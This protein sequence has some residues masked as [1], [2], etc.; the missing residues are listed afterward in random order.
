MR[1]IHSLWLCALIASAVAC[2]AQVSA[3]EIAQSD[4]LARGISSYNRKDYAGAQQ[5]LLKAVNGEFKNVAVAHYYLANSLM[6]ASKTNAALDE[7]ERCYNLAPFSSFSGYCRMMLIRHGKNP[8]AVNKTALEKQPREQPKEQ[9]KEKQTAV[10]SKPATDPELA[11]L[12]SRLPRPVVITK[13]SPPASDILAGNI[14]YRSGFLGEAEIRKNRA[15]EK[16]EQ[17][18]QNLTRAESLT[19]SFVP[20]AKSFGESD[21]EFRNRRADAEKSVTSLLDPFKENVKEAETAFQN[22]SALFESCLN[23]SRGFQY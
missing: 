14:N 19:H 10:E 8:D 5:Y 17:A 21:E 2:V 12:S 15:F 6:Q 18:R 22:E 4:L 1:S 20:S 13:E 9:L 7:Y 23:A 3:A 16:V 11:K